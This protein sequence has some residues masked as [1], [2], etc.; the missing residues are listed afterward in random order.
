MTRRKGSEGAG[1]IQTGI[2]GQIQ[3]ALRPLAGEALRLRH[4]EVRG[5]AH[6]HGFRRRPVAGRPCLL[7]KQRGKVG[8]GQEPATTPP[9]P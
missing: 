4:V 6:P 5:H 3:A 9:P 8:R 2:H 1:S 7:S